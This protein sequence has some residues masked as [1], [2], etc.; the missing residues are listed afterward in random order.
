[1][2]LYTY[3]FVLI[4]VKV[5]RDLGAKHQHDI[6]K[7]K[8]CVTFSGIWNKWCIGCRTDL[9]DNHDGAIAFKK[10]SKNMY[11]NLFGIEIS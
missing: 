3:I 6:N 8:H 10:Y 4:I 1:M 2:K 9:T 11:I 5:Y 7:R